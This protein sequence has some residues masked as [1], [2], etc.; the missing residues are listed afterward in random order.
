MAA[1][2][3]VSA[4]ATP[5]L[6]LAAR[7]GRPAPGRDRRL[8]L[9]D[10]RTGTPADPSA[11]ILSRGRRRSGNRRQGTREKDG[12]SSRVQLLLRY[13]WLRSHPSTGR[14]CS[15]LSLSRSPVVA[16]TRASRSAHVRMCVGTPN[17]NDDAIAISRPFTRPPLLSSRDILPI[18]ILSGSRGSQAAAH[19]HHPDHSSCVRV[20]V[21][22]S[23]V[24]AYGNSRRFCLP[25]LGFSQIASPYCLSLCLV[26]HVKT[27]ADR[28]TE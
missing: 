7:G 3:T 22:V 18:R 15:S 16:H 27:L 24:V 12:F 1:A 20:C 6:I 17:N 2:G 11:R 5:A 13:R 8:L 4:A 14:C 23:V 21:R 9:E 25:T 26:S 10:G 28:V 19:H